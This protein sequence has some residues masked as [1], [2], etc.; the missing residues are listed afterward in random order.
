MI[1]VSPTEQHM[2]RL[3]APLILLLL[4][5]ASAATACGKQEPPRIPLAQGAPVDSVRAMEA[6]HALL[7]PAAR[8]ELDS[9]NAFYRKKEYHEALVRYRAASELAPQHAAP[10]FG[11]YMVARVTNNTKLADSALAGIRLRNG[12]LPAAPHS[13]GDSA[14]RRMHDIIRQKAKAG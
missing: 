5:L 2:P 7:G 3:R 9:G 13:L 1:T 10:L 4:T 11:I 8:A 12:P 6:A 14:L